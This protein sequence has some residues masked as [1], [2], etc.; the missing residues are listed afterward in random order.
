MEF[1]CGPM[2]M[3]NSCLKENSSMASR[4]LVGLPL[5][6]EKRGWDSMKERSASSRPSWD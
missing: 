5:T 2:L 3:R 4:T 6:L 1:L